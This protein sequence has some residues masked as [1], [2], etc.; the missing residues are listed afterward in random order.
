MLRKAQL[1]DMIYISRKVLR[2]PAQDQHLVKKRETED[3]SLQHGI[4]SYYML[5]GLKGRAV[6]DKDGIIT[7]SEIFSYIFRKVAEA[8]AQDQHPAKKGETGGDLV[9]GRTK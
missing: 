7:I 1:I 6:Q 3:D 2:A 5:E 8:Y 4:F 9:I